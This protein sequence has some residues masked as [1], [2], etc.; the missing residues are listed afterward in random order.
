MTTEAEQAQLDNPLNM[1]RVVASAQGLESF[2]GQGA[3]VLPIAGIAFDHYTV[4]AGCRTIE[5]KPA[6]IA[7]TASGVAVLTKACAVSVNG[8]AAMAEPLVVQPADDPIRIGVNGGDKINVIGDTGTA[9][10][11]YI[12]P[13]G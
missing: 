3:I 1:R 5:I 8:T 10:N 13:L 2:D 4:P 11:I 9:G 6:A 7:V 12:L